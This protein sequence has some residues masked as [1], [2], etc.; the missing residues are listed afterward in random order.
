MGALIRS[1]SS[2]VPIEDHYG[3]FCLQT[4]LLLHCLDLPVSLNNA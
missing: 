2:L 4:E 1:V 3:V